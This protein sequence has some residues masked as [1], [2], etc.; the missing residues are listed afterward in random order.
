MDCRSLQIQNNN[1]KE[2][3]YKALKECGCHDEEIIQAMHQQNVF[4]FFIIHQL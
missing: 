3:V 4:C 2:A 1:N